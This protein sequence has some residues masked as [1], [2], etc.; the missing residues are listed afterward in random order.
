[1][2]N[3]EFYLFPCLKDN[4]GCLVHDP[5]TGAT[6]AI[7]A[8]EADPVKAA[9]HDKGWS[10]SEIFITHHHGDHTAGVAEL[11]AET[12]CKVVG[13]KAE[14]DRIDHLDQTVSEGDTLAFAGHPVEILST[15]GHTLGHITYLFK[16][17]DTA[18]C[19]DTL[20]ALGCGRVFEGTNEMMWQSLQKLM[21]LPPETTI[22]CGHEYTAGNAAF[23]LTVDPDNTALRDRAK[24][25][26]EMRKDGAATVPFKLSLELATNPFLRPHDPSIRSQ[27][28]LE[29]A[30]DAEVF[31][32]LRER[33]NKA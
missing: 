2:S 16:S 28:Q 14:A 10:L 23:A 29:N 30:S 1:M 5:K 18:F 19:G 31:A 11:K 3:L 13:P 12:G 24:L 17:E 21:R 22:Y 6:V 32:E 4:Y 15:P 8:P 26:A 27:L 7:D 25:I 20:F 9:L 33:K